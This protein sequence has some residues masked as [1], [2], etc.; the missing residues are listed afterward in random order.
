MLVII[1]YNAKAV[2]GNA[3]MLKL[4]W[5]LYLIYVAIVLIGLSITLPNPPR[6]ALYS[7]PGYE[8]LKY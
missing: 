3:T 6:I 7:F 2:A 1:V 4:C 5:L 8:C